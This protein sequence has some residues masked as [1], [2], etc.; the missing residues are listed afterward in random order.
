MSYLLGLSLLCHKLL[1]SYS[2]DF[3]AHLH[4]IPARE[5]S[6]RQFLVASASQMQYNGICQ[7]DLQWSTNIGP[8]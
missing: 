4:T 2:E 8:H 3:N 1:M 6:S 5:L 7:S